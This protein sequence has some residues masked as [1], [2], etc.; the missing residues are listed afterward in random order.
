MKSATQRGQLCAC[1]PHVHCNIVHKSQDMETIYESINKSMEKE[2]VA[3]IQA[4]NIIQ[5]LKEMRQFVTKRVNFE[6]IML[7]E[8]SQTEK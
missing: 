7:S 8:I 6:D 5:V 4:R 2:I 1:M 3:Y